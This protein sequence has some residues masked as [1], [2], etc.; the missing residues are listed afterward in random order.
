MSQASGTSAPESTED[1]QPFSTVGEKKRKKNQRSSTQ[2][3]K[4]NDTKSPEIRMN[5]PLLPPPQKNPQNKVT[6][7]TSN[8][9]QKKNNQ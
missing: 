6:N 5:P 9:S 7:T 4:L 3:K 2:T 1:E 8:N